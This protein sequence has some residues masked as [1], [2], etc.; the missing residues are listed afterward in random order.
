[1]SKIKPIDYLWKKYASA[2]TET[3]PKSRGSE[4][5]GDAAQLLLFTEAG[6]TDSTG[7]YILNGEARGLLRPGLKT[8]IY[9]S[10]TY[11]EI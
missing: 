4:Q 8:R 9:P 5:T 3:L 1:M 7:K 10:F 11:S 2:K 6:K